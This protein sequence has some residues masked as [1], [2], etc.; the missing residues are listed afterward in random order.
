MT[1][2]NLDPVAWGSIVAVAISV[3]IVVFLVFKIKALVNR[4]AEAHKN[5]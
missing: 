4:D 2:L 3:I 1:L 5:Q